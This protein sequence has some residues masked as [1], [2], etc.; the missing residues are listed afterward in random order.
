MVLREKW[1]GYLKG[2]DPI[3]DTSVFSLNHDGRKGNIDDS[4]PIQKKNGSF[5][6]QGFLENDPAAH[7]APVTD[8]IPHLAP[9]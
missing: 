2:N 6:N 8:R 4:L 7:L 3:G 5:F 9:L 1:A